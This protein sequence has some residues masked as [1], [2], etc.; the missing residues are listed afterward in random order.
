VLL[1]GNYQFFHHTLAVAVCDIDQINSVRQ[2]ADIHR[3]LGLN[4]F[5]RHHDPSH[6]IDDADFWILK[7]LR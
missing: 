6:Q 3:L 1:F 7:S 4:G 2:A 5:G